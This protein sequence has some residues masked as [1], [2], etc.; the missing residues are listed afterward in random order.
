M[1]GIEFLIQL[2][3]RLSVRQRVILFHA[4]A[5]LFLGVTL[6]YL[7]ISDGE[8]HHEAHKAVIPNLESRPS[9]GQHAHQNAGYPK[10]G[11]EFNTQP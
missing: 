4:V 10:P 1:I 9:L 7:F 8:L 11:P 2:L 3:T 5:M 6:G